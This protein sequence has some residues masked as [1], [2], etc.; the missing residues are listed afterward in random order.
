MFGKYGIVCKKTIDDWKQEN[1]G[2]WNTLDPEDLP[3][4]YFVKVEYGQKKSKRMYYKLPDGSELV[5]KYN[6]AGKYR[7][8]DLIKGDGIDRSWLNQ[9]FYYQRI[10]TRE[11]FHIYKKISQVIDVK[12]NEVMVT[13][14]DYATDILP[15]GL[16]GD[17]LSDYKFWMQKKSCD[18][19]GFNESRVM[20]NGLKYTITTGGN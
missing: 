5:A 18:S 12:T 20:F 17:R 2:V 19:E 1:P 16:I 8:T 14:V 4:E 15:I 10:I 9:R 6:A 11:Y 7:M 3:E 13:Y